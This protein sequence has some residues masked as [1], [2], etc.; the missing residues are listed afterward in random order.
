MRTTSAMLLAALLAGCATP[1]GGLAASWAARPHAPVAPRRAA[2]P[3]MPIGVPKVS[4]AP[5]LI[6]A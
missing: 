4:R 3:V 1:A 6:A 5:R 2:A